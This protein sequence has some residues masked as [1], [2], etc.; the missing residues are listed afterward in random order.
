MRRENPRL[1]AVFGLDRGRGAATSARV[2]ACYR[3]APS[4]MRMQRSSS[5][6]A[7]AAAPPRPH[8]AT[9]RRALLTFY[10][11]H[12]RDLP[13]RRTRDPYAIWLSEVLLQQT[14]VATVVPRYGE[15]LRRFPD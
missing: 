8:I 6:M 12:G 13:W 1:D 3:Y 5:E 7:R 4:V 14:Q 10:R 11:I 9:L 2:R 15:L